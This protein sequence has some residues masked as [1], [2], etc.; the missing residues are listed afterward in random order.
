M[1][2]VRWKKVDAT[3]SI[4][5]WSQLEELLED[6]RSRSWSSENDD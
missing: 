6:R 2:E 5:V 1:E 3:H 4:G